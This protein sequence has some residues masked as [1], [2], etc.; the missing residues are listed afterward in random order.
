MCYPAG[1]VTR[2]VTAA[3]SALLLMALLIA[4]A[5]A[6]EAP[7]LKG[8]ALIIGQS[9]YAHV[10]PLAN[11]ATDARAVNG[12]L[13]ALGFDTRTVTD[14]DADKLKRD[15][16]RFA[17][18]AEGADVA[19]LYYSGHGIEAG[20]ENYLIP[21]DAD[22]SS[23]D[24]AGERL[25][26]LS[27][28]MDRLKRGVPVTILLLD[29]CR[30]NPFPPNAALKISKQASSTP[31][32]PIGLGAPRGMR[33][34][35]EQAPTDNLGMVIG[36]AAEPG[37]AAL[38]GE[39]GGNSPY[40]AAL[41]RHFSA[42][43]GEEFGTVMRM[44]TEEVYLATKTRQRPWINESLR[45]LLYFGG[46][47]QDAGG[48]SGLITQERRHLL[49]TIT[50]LPL[51]KRQQVEAIAEK[52][53]VPLDALFSV[54]RSLGETDMPDDPV[55]LDKF[56]RK[57][58]ETL[59]KMAADRNA[60]RSDNARI[61]QFVSAADRATDQGAIATAR[62]FL[63]QA[64]AIVEQG[65]MSADDTGGDTTERR[66]TDAAVYGLR[67]KTA[68]LG[69]D[70][71]AAANDYG[72][73]FELIEKK[74]N[75]LAWDYKFEAGNMLFA[76]GDTRKDTGSLKR[77]VQAYETALSFISQKYDSRN[78]ARTQL[79]LG[80]TLQAL[81][82]NEMGSDKLLQAAAIFKAALVVI[83][84][85]IDPVG[86][87]MAQTGLGGA[88]QLLGDREAGS[89]SLNQA[90]SA[91][92]AG[93]EAISREENPIHWGTVQHNLGVTLFTLGQREAG[94]A[95]L[96]EALEAYRAAMQELSRDKFP[97][98][99][100]RA[101][102]NLGNALRVLGE[103]EGGTD[104]LQDAVAAYRAALE[105]EM[106]AKMPLRWAV[107]QSNLGTALRS[108]GERENGTQ[109]LEES[110]AAYHAALEELTPDLAPL[111][112]S[113]AQN[114]LGNALTTI[115]QRDGNIVRFKE[116]VAAF[117]GALQQRSR[118]QTPTL[119]AQTQNNLAS[120]LALI[121]QQENDT[122]SLEKAAA[123]FRAVMQVRTR[124]DA[125]YQWALAQ[126][127]LGS[128]LQELG[129]QRNDVSLLTDAVS[130]HRSALLELTRER[131]PQEW[132]KVQNNLGNALRS[133]G[134]RE[135]GTRSL[136][137][138]LTALRAALEERSREQSPYQWARTQVNIGLT[139]L[140]LSKRGGGNKVAD[141]AIAAF[142]EALSVFQEA[143]ATRDIAR[144]ANLL[145][146]AHALKR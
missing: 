96:H 13:T 55:A 59:R 129:E 92:R 67:A 142:K 35:E 117:R 130:A 14:R 145:A 46:A 137:Q 108:I 56:L 101:Q 98:E 120:A 24:E 116:A 105:I 100:A 34:V 66:I 133:L 109:S 10:T 114:N 50:D 18:D 51:A 33:V 146:E 28:I 39:P 132:S 61:A 37:R 115:G 27:K 4:T 143:N 82:E 90:V 5:R 22:P 139:L 45:R 32:S 57:Q 7:T 25:V 99:W 88:L 124:A 122:A 48:E 72:R 135:T 134:E 77:A 138:A 112:W 62:S 93:L 81:G 107:T 127:N 30:T 103:R 94:T 128:V 41:L 3:V 140:T 123:A 121:G 75:A 36:L 11:P 68:S 119:W 84:R 60:L 76:Q 78:W 89:E 1:H 17:E 2:V 6:E 80:N 43:K 16:D 38:D 19:L 86:W 73:A 106:R 85:E 47:G 54:L 70:Y 74:N 83:S 131:V 15:L 97:D 113:M 63:D 144:V 110:V 40:A 111:D 126:S 31:L 26:P 44:V 58:A 87:S 102:N 64:V 8:V 125:P 42:I 91:Y 49:L 20:G 52:D 69:L 136:K 118:E 23:L 71:L 79:N 104:R 21:T 65:Q 53:G 29:A 95:T 12:L 141:A 9:R